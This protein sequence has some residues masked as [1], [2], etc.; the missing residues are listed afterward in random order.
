MTYML[1]FHFSLLVLCS[2]DDAYHNQFESFRN[3]LKNEE[4][5]FIGKNHTIT[6]RTTITS[7]LKVL[8]TNVVFH[9]CTYSSGYGGA[10]YYSMAGG[11]VLIEFSTFYACTANHNGGAISIYNCKSDFAL[12][13]VCGFKCYTTGGNQFGHGYGQFMYT[14]LGTNNLDYKGSSAISLSHKYNANRM[15]ICTYGGKQIYTSV[16]IS[17]NSATYYATMYAMD[18]TETTYI[19]YCSLNANNVTGAFCL[20]ITGT[21]FLIIDTCN[22]I[23]NDIGSDSDYPDNAVIT[24]YRK[25]NISNCCILGNYA[26]KSKPKMVLYCSTTMILCDSCIEGKFSRISTYNVI[27]DSDKFYLNNLKFTKTENYCDTGIEQVG[28]L[29]PIPDL[30]ITY[31]QKIYN[32]L[33]AV[34]S[35]STLLFS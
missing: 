28:D 21:G 34:V 14:S 31:E 7:A 10:V 35:Y 33:R 30:F 19:T 4:D 5:Y 2:I 13:C 25:T 32:R 29:T 9:K 27:T 11:K 3:E 24:S 18:S 26:Y 12:Y 1:L 15:A 6:T 17:Y 8:I 22:L 23:N 16:N 20:Y